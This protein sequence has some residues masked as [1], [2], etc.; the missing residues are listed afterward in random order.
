MN[1]NIIKNFELLIDKINNDISNSTG[2]QKNV[3][4][5]RLRSIEIGLNIIKKFKKNLNVQKNIN[6][7]ANIKGI[8]KGILKRIKEI[9]E[10]GHLEELKDFAKADKT[11]NELT[12]VFGIGDAYANK[13]INEYNITTVSQLKKAVSNQIIK[14][15]RS[16]KLGLKYSSKFKEHILRSEMKLHSKFLQRVAKSID[17]DLLLKV[18]GSYRRKQ[19]YSNDIDCVLTY[20]GDKSSHNYLD[21]FVNKLI[22]SNYI[23]DEITQ[24][25]KNK[26]M[27]FCVSINPK[28]HEINKNIVRRI[29]IEYI[30]FDQYPTALLYFTG[31]K[32]FNLYLRK[33]AK[34][35]GYKL[36]EFGLYKGN[37]KIQNIKS[38]KDIFKI[39]EISYVKPEH[40]QSK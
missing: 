28:T 29:D 19:P 21:L 8:G 1:K 26:S 7:L 11:V 17:K 20:T 15:T 27:G 14:P 13:L 32:Y 10:N 2:T 24:S 31:D 6:E 18:C 3:N 38:E 16:I 23:L 39:L 9:N 5:Y 33:L 36:S 34:S 37:K 4:L 22:E 12:N 30:T 40:R 35:K 25:R